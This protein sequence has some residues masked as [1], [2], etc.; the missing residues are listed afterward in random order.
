MI[1]VIENERI[2]SQYAAPIAA[3]FWKVARLPDTGPTILDKQNRLI[4]LFE[5]I[6]KYTSA[7]VL[8]YYRQRL[9]HVE[10]VETELTQ[11]P[12]RPSLG[13][14]RQL[15]RELTKVYERDEQVDLLIQTLCKTFGHK[16]DD[17]KRIQLYRDAVDLAPNQGP[18]SKGRISYGDVCDRLVSYRNWLVKRAG[19][20][21]TQSQR[22]SHVPKIQALLTHMLID[23]ECLA[24]FPL[25]HVREISR[26]ANQKER[27]QI[28][29]CMGTSQLWHRHSVITPQGLSARHCYVC[30]PLE[31]GQLRPLLDLHPF[32]VHTTCTEDDCEQVFAVSE[33]SDK[34]VE[35]FSY[36][37][38]HSFKPDKSDDLNLKADM[39]K[40]LIREQWVEHLVERAL[41][42]YGTLLQFPL[43]LLKRKEGQPGYAEEYGEM[44][45]AFMHTENYNL[46][47][48][49]VRKLFEQHNIN[50]PSGA[51]LP[52]EPA[53]PPVA[54]PQPTDSE[55]SNMEPPELA[56]I[57]WLEVTPERIKPGQ[58]AVLRWCTQN[59]A[60]V[61]L[62]PGA[63]NIDA[64]GRFE[65]RPSQTT[66]YTLSA[67]NK[68]GDL[69]SESISVEV[70]VPTRVAPPGSLEELWRAELPELPVKLLR[71]PQTG[72]SLAVGKE[73]GICLLA[74]DGREVW[75]T[76][77]PAP[78]RCATFAGGG[79]QL[80][81]ADWN[82]A[83][84]CYDE[85]AQRPV[86]EAQVPGVIAAIE[87]G[88]WN[89]MSGAFVGTWRQGVFF[90][91]SSGQVHTVSRTD[92]TINA[93]VAFPHHE[94]CAVGDWEGGVSIF[95][96]R[97]E[98]PR[99]VLLK[100]PVC[101][102]ATLPGVD[103]IVVVTARNNFYALT[104]KG[105]VVWLYE[106]SAPVI[107]W[108]FAPKAASFVYGTEAGQHYSISFGSNGR[109]SV[110][111]KMLRAPE[112]VH[113]R[114]AI[115]V[116]GDYL[117]ARNR[118]G[119]LSV[120]AGEILCQESKDTA[121]VSEFYLDPFAF[122]LLVGSG[123]SVCALRNQHKLRHSRPVQLVTSLTPL[124]TFAT[125]RSTIVEIQLSNIGERP[126]TDVRGHLK[127]R[128]AQPVTFTTEQMLPGEVVCLR[129][130]VEPQ[131][132]GQFTVGAELSYRD[133]EEM[134][135]VQLSNLLTIETQD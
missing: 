15:H 75:R 68:A 101:S 135:T 48:P 122:T 62:D 20:S 65:V 78:L 23:L 131:V 55:S 89:G 57:E 88:K 93:L 50:P 51:F 103:R 43:A 96:S 42:R 80:L 119:R 45:Q 61:T 121:P 110:E 109:H 44:E 97:D 59:A 6:L 85:H 126:A 37:C 1:T 5:I 54:E 63:N 125:G 95:D 30:M 26:Q 81:T 4:D 32:V 79:R 38:G 35:Y 33:G 29:V 117:A 39:H 9:D 34:E 17:R 53:K 52:T 49:V 70:L 22:E 13:E 105:E 106:S 60:H 100:E 72:L 129:L 47:Q 40:L 94:G 25:V 82:G 76:T 134:Q 69:V 16:S 114:L 8:S 12:F 14:W 120:Y 56:V 10:S 111:E 112:G 98:R 83:I 115:D 19:R 31:D 21:S 92:T 18:R 90:C 28:D 104:E 71:S 128:F 74:K 73:G 64:E 108:A 36:E 67:V 87:A 66:R 58:P 77:S 133:C 46:P 84:R 3:A 102:L 123:H 91:S 127:G 118:D 132:K 24:Q 116:A 113:D 107:S 86:W 130:E 27:A 41:E 11:Q 124:G 2:N 7:I 99:R